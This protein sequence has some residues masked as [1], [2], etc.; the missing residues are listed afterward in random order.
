[1]NAHELPLV[2]T[3]SEVASV[4]RIGRAA[5]Y[6]LVRERALASVRVGRSLRVPRA[7]LLNWLA[8]AGD[9]SAH[10]THTEEV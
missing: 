6:Q 7:S 2:L 3:V 9:E 4:L 5:A 1:M 10:L 8:A